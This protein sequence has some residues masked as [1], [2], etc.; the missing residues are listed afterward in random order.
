MEAKIKEILHLGVIGPSVSLYS[1]QVVLVLK[2][3]GLVPFCIDFVNCTTKLIKMQ[4]HCQIWKR[5]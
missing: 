3:D 5:S 2:T 4:G 1:S